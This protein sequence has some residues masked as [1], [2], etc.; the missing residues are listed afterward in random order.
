MN[1]KRKAILVMVAFFAMGTA[2]LISA[3]PAAAMPPN[4]PLFECEES[5]GDGG[6]TGGGSGGG[7]APQPP[8]PPGG[9]SP[10]GGTGG[11]SGGWGY[12]RTPPLDGCDGWP[13]DPLCP[14]L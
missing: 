7:G 9:G 11:N 1:K 8:T 4:C 2:N 5:G 6:T 10:D 12:P 13:K 14:R 3:G